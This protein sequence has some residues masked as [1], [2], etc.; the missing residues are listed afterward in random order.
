MGLDI[1]SSD[2]EKS[3]H[4]GYM[5]FSV[6][7]SFFVLHYSKELYYKYREIMDRLG[8]CSDEEWENVCDNVNN[9]DI[10]LK[11]SDCDG[12]LSSDECKLLINSLFVDEEKIKSLSYADEEYRNR[13]IRLMYEF[14]TLIRYCAENDDVELIFG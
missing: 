8:F 14:I 5:S 12:E 7:R 6:M 4:I 2:Y 3:F 9:L 11:H 10:L 1:T 13:M